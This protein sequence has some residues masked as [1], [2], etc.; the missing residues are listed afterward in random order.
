MSVTVQINHAMLEWSKNALAPWQHEAFRRILAKGT[1][2]EQDK[3]DIYKRAQHDLGFIAPSNSLPDVTLTNADLPTALLKSNRIWLLALKN[4]ENVNALK[5]KQRLGIGKHLTVVYG[6]NGSGK[7]GYARV[8]KRTVRCTE[9]AVESILPDV[10]QTTTSSAPAKA[11]FELDNGTGPFDVP[12]QDGKPVA[13]DLKRFAV[14][15]SKCARHFLDSSNQLSFAPAI[16]D[17]LRVLGENTAE[18]KQRFLDLA[19]ISAPATPPTFQF[20]VDQT[21]VGKALASISTSTDPKKISA[22]AQWTQ[23]DEANLLRKEADL[24]KLQT[25]SPQAIRE[26]IK[27]EKRDASTIQAQLAKVVNVLEDTKVLELKGLVSDL[28]TQEQTVQTAAKLA[29]NDSTIEGVGTDAWR[30]LIIAA[31]NFSTSTAY[32]G[33][34]F[35]PAI[36][37][38][39]CVLCQ[40]P[41]EGD[42]STR[43]KRFWD[44]LQN[45]AAT[46]RD[47]TRQKLNTALTHLKSL[48][49]ELPTEVNHLAEVFEKRHAELRQKTIQFFATAPGR[50]DEIQKAVVDGH[51]EKISSLNSQSFTMAQLLVSALDAKLKTVQDDAKIQAETQKLTAEVVELQSRKRLEA[52]LKIVLD[53]I[54]ALRTTAKAQY[55]ANHIATNSISLKAKELHTTFITDAFKENV[56]AQMKRVGLHRTRVAID[57]RSERGKVLH[58]II[59]D[60]AKQ[61]VTPG[62][63]FSEGE[64]TAISFAFFMN[65]LGSVGDTC[66]VI[67]DDP[68]TSLDHRIREG[69]IRVLVNE[70]KERQV[71]VF[72]HDLAFY[73]ELVSAATIAQIGIVSNHVESF[74]T[75]IGHL[76]GT[77]PREVLKVT[78]RYTEM[79]RL[80]N[81]AEQS[82]SP[83]E[84][85][86]AVDR[87]Y[88]LLRAAWERSVEELLFNQVVSRNQ[89]DV[90][91]LKL[92]GV[93]IDKDSIAAVFQGMTRGSDRTEA[94]DHAP[95]TALP[96]PPVEDLKTHLQ[97]LKNFVTAQTAKRKFAE[98]Q[99]KHLKGK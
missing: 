90:M 88:S 96:T 34:P 65:D 5:A 72:T 89:K 84:F 3:N 64:R 80:V 63:I 33:Q 9:K 54:D 21:S 10:F 38:A 13:D 43:L 79:E 59:V 36:E 71:I 53:H 55:A 97:E 18:I 83:D 47:A 58:S 56:K 32:K 14:F 98:E 42:A 75:T 26:Q 91:T 6:E 7:S 52:N 24:K 50:M 30:N 87:F 25:T 27:A 4:L 1:L 62:S 11:V 39:V 46:K 99:N 94:H 23:Q 29:F 86:N 8:L 73:C 85:H 31:A 16:F 74:S 37:D 93:A 44:F 76:S 20:M 60:G 67:F 48:P 40:Q 15:D 51:W 66:G 2:T 57:E 78:Q 41:L 22:L 28:A 81:D 70:A 17:A 92:V 45:A 35:P 68:V 95:G 61:A 12:W 77:E 69:V 19:R 82:K 49:R